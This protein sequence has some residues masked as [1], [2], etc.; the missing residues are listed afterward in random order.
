MSC[1][2]EIGFRLRRPKSKAP[3]S[4]LPTSASRFQYR[5]VLTH[6]PAVVFSPYRSNLVIPPHQLWIRVA[7]AIQTQ[8][9]TFANR[10]TLL[11]L[12]HASWE[13]AMRAAKLL[14]YACR[15]RWSAA[16]EEVAFRVR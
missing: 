6:G 12:P 16:A 3:P 4:P 9:A 13:E 1:R 11:D 10:P 15:H 2:R 7:L 8:Y 5:A 14:E